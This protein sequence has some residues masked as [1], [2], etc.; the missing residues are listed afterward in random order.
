MDNLRRLTQCI[1]HVSSDARLKPLHLALYLVLC[2]EWIATQFQ[3]PYNISRRKM[4]AA[5]RI[6][7][8]AT[9][10]KII[11]ELKSFGYLRYSPSYHPV[12]GSSVSLTHPEI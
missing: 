2:N 11:K 1:S 6:R 5:S 4:M 12:K 3:S 8:K 9:Y 7:S 10:H